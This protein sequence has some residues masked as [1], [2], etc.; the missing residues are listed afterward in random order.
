MH[1]HSNENELQEVDGKDAPDK[2]E[3]RKRH[4]VPEDTLGG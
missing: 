1:F 2:I 3:I 4:A